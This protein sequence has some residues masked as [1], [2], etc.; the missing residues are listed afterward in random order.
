MLDR[1]NLVG[2]I[3]IVKILVTYFDNKNIVSFLRVKL[4]NEEVLSSH[5]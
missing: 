5:K 2:K 3:F 1:L 4:L